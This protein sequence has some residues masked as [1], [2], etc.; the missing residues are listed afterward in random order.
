M[1]PTRNEATA[2][3]KRPSELQHEEWASARHLEGRS[4][5]L[6][7]RMRLCRGLRLP[8]TAVVRSFPKFRCYERAETNERSAFPALQLLDRIHNGR[9]PSIGSKLACTF[10]PPHRVKLHPRNRS[11]LLRFPGRHFR[12][13]QLPLLLILRRG[14]QC[15]S[16][17]DL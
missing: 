1:V 7:P 16:T 2:S 10:G 6:P 3:S 8:N 9:M 5:L 14:E 12:A 4:V 15:T 11:S 17:R 13:R